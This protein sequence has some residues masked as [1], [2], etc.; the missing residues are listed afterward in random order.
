M[1]V[2]G[3]IR[4]DELLG[5]SLQEIL[6]IEGVSAYYLDSLGCVYRYLPKE[7]GRLWVEYYLDTLKR[8][9]TLTLTWEHEDFSVLT[10]GYQRIRSFYTQRYGKAEGPV[11]NIHWKTPH[12]KHIHLRISPERRY[13]HLAMY[14]AE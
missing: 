11:G 8:V 2:F 7:G 9:R 10:Q 12:K 13:I 4:R 3:G 5:I 6:T 14:A 1:L